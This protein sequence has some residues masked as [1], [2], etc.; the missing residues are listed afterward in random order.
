MSSTNLLGRARPAHLKTP[1]LAKQTIS[2]L[3]VHG[4]VSNTCAI[5]PGVLW[6]LT[7]RH[8]FGVGATRPLA[9]TAA[10]AGVSPDEL[11]ALAAR[12]VKDRDL[13][14]HL[15][16]TPASSQLVHSAKDAS[17]TTDS[18]STDKNTSS[19]KNTSKIADRL[20]SD[21]PLPTQRQMRLYFINNFLPFV[22]FGFCDNFIMLVVG[23]LVDA[24]LGIA[25]GISTLAAAAIGNTVSDV[26]GIWASGFIETTNAALG[27]PVSG[28]TSRQRADIRMRILKNTACATGI[29]LGC[30]LGMAPLAYPQEWRL[31]ESRESL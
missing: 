1:Q 23:D 15:A 30:L 10:A 16:L 20:V 2:S 25:F 28:L 11:Q 18:S 7:H 5:V 4:R 26:V 3:G 21:V 12:I 9:T 19:V 31:W 22:G 29:I 14:V 13:A 6:H 17:S 8:G 27:I 24:K